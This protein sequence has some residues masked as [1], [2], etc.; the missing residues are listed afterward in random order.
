MDLSL[1]WRDPQP[2]PM[3]ASRVVATTVTVWV[4]SAPRRDGG[5][6]LLDGRRLLLS[7]GGR[8]QIA[9]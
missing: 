5:Q 1:E 4:G 9:Q 2:A 3:P 8:R 7:V 6:G